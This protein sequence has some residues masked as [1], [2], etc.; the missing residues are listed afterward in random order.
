MNTK[1]KE[2]EVLV[3]PSVDMASKIGTEPE[4]I[5]R[6]I[7]NT[8]LVKTLPFVSKGEKGNIFSRRPPVN[9]KFE[10]IS[11]AST[12]FNWRQLKLGECKIFHAFSLFMTA[13]LH[14]FLPVLYLYLNRYDLPIF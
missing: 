10:N 5:D 14:C 8:K 6:L 12:H 1:I 7:Y 2:A 13:T 11:Y 4:N 9:V 3:S